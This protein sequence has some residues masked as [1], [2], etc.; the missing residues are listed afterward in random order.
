MIEAE[1]L[2]AVARRGPLWTPVCGIRVGWAWDGPE[3]DPP[4]QRNTPTPPPRLWEAR[5]PGWSAPRRT[6]A[7]DHRQ[8]LSGR[9]EPQLRG[10]QRR[11]T[12]GAA[13]HAGEPNKVLGGR[14]S[15]AK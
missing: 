6:P 2:T 8:A 5:R 14:G 12:I 10:G 1:R 15:Q 13:R 3:L 4:G 9:N 7:H 11:L